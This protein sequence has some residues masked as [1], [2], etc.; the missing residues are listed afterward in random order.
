MDRGTPIESS[1]P[2][3]S[4]APRSARWKGWARDAAIVIVIFAAVR[5]YQTWDLPSGP[6]PPIDGHDLEGRALSLGGARERP[7]LVHFFATWCGVCRAEQPNVS[8]IARDHDVLLVATSSPPLEVR[9]WIAHEPVEPADV[10]MDRDASIARAFGVRAFPTSFWVGTDG[11]IR[12][13]EVGYTSE[14]G[15]RLRFWM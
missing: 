2:A 4:A 1:A 8:A 14:L 9:E 15:M 6:V 13:V 10:L 5:L 7:V 11:H 3:A 12:H